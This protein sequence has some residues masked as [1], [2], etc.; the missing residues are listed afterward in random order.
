MKKILIYQLISILILVFVLSCSEQVIQ[1]EKPSGITVE[2]AKEWFLNKY[3]KPSRVQDN[4][5]IFR[6][7]FWDAAYEHKTMGTTVIVVPITHI[8]K[9]QQRGIKQLWVYN[10]S[11]GEMI[12]RV[13][14]YIFPEKSDRDFNYK[15]FSD[16]N[17]KN[18]SG[19]LLIRDWDNNFIGGYEIINNKK[20]SFI[21]E[22]SNAKSEKKARPSATCYGE[23]CRLY[24]NYTVGHPEA[25]FSYMSCLSFS[26]QCPDLL[27]FEM[28]NGGG[29]FDPAANAYDPFATL[30]YRYERIVSDPCGALKRMWQVQ[31]NAGKEITAWKTTT[32]DMIILPTDQNTQNASYSTGVFLGANGTPVAVIT[33]INN[34]WVAELYNGNGVSNGTFQLTEMYHTHPWMPAGVSNAFPSGDDLNWYNSNSNG[35]TINAFIVHHDSIIKYNGSGTQ[36]TVSNNCRDY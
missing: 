25:D 17:L 8:Y 6:Q 35:G 10:N 31:R 15:K 34:Q 16:R 30:Q 3:E 22:I 28:D 29:G 5:E 13:I 4:K 33:N 36:S 20:I 26:W 24:K 1:N 14:E 7:A 12:S 21:T 18:F 23:N 2:I 9:N 27:S 32:G 11:K 19:V